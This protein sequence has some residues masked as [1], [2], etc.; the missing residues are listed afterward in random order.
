MHEDDSLH[1]P[2][3]GETARRIWTWMHE[4]FGAEGM[5]DYYMLTRASIELDEA[6]EKIEDDP[7]GT[8]EMAKEVADVLIVLLGL[9][10]KYTYQPQVLVEQ[11]M[12]V[13]RARKWEY[14]NGRWQHV[15][16]R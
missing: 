4:T 6:L 7:E 15:A 13:N 9:L 3:D 8:H 16:V 12:R 2:I 5:T 11:K 1:R 14:V 10:G